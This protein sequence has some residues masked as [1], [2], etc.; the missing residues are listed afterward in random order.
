[1]RDVANQVIEQIKV[2]IKPEQTTMEMQLNPESL[3][4]VNQLITQKNGVLTDQFTVQNEIAKEAIEG[5]MHTLKENFTQQG[6]K[7][8]AVEVTVSN[9]PFSQDN[10]SKENGEQH[11]SSGK[12]KNIN[13]A[14]LDLVDGELTEEDQVV[15]DMMNQNGNSV[16]YSA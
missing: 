6:L 7:V 4:K 5:Q 3:G 8:E 11:K 10:M 12:R 15:V 2:V 13:L 16:D 9:L 1:M 14:D